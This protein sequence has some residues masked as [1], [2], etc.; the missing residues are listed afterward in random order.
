MNNKDYYKDL[1]PKGTVIELIESI[2]DPYT[3]KPSGSRF[4]VDGVDDICQ[5]TGHWLPPQTGSISVII[6][7]DKFRVVSKP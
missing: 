4:V 1:Y 7:H 5:L 2:D 6:E 3:P